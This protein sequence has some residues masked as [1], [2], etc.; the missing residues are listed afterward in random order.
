MRRRGDLLVT[1]YAVAAQVELHVWHPDAGLLPRLVLAAGV[2]ALLAR[3]RFTVAAPLACAAA[4]AAMAPLDVVSGTGLGIVTAGIAAAL[5]GR[6]GRRATPALGVLV[7]LVLLGTAADMV[8]DSDLVTAPLIVLAVA[9]ASAVLY[10]ARRQVDDVRAQIAELEARDDDGAQLLSRERRRV[11]RELH[12]VVSHHLTVA[13]LQAGGARV[14]LARVGA[15]AAVAD[16]LQAAEE[17]GRRAV[18]DLRPLLDV[19]G[20]EQGLAPQPGLAQLPQLVAQVRG[21]GVDVRLSAVEVD[22]PPGLD[23]V[24]YRVLQEALTNAARHGRGCADVRVTAEGGRLL[25]QVS[26]DLA[27][28]PRTSGG[29]GLVGMRERVALYGGRLDARRRGG[30]WTVRAELPLPDPAPVS[31]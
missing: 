1:A 14:Q 26:N 27:G 22:L 28:G 2:L 17:A 12:D 29:H 10:R 16:A 11:A 13:A 7:V 6:Q 4:G 20:G 8:Q 21:A 23:L 30:R 15:T 3:D 31:A 5:L 19:V 25:L 9:G 18:A 24:A